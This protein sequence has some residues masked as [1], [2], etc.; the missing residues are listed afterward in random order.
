MPVWTVFWEQFESL[1]VVQVET[2]TAEDAAIKAAEREGVD[3][4]GPT[5]VYVASGPATLVEVTVER[6][7]RAK[8]QG[9]T[10]G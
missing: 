4:F 1:V 5:H 6:Y 3:G 7:Y 9:S 8:A 10:N 2:E